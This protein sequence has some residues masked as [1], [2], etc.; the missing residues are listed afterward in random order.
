MTHMTHLDLQQLEPGLGPVALSYFLLFG[1]T[2][3]KQI[4]H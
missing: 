2:L 3:S 4:P 1:L